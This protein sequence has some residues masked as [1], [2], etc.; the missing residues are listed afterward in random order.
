MLNSLEIQENLNLKNLTKMK[1]TLI[2]FF[3]TKLH[4][5]L[6]D[7]YINSSIVIFL[8]IL[9][10]VAVDRNDQNLNKSCMTNGCIVEGA[11]MG[12]F[13]MDL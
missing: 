6:F 13:S 11:S 12:V 5:G 4:C 8:K 10:N 2:F 7:T 9:A 3:N 1:E